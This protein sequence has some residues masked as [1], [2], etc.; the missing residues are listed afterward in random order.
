M[1]DGFDRV[2]HSRVYLLTFTT[3][4]TRLHGDNRGTVDRSHSR[5]GQPLAGRDPDR[6]MKE[7][8]L[9]RFAPMVL[10]AARRAIV[11]ATV[12]EV[13]RHR[14]WSLLALNVRT[15]HIHAVVAGLASPEKMMNDLK[16]YSTRRLVEAHECEPGHRVW[17][18]HGSLRQLSTPRAVEAACRY[19]CE[20]QGEDLAGGGAEGLAAAR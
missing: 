3:Y 8:L 18:R 2:V 16:A 20:G 15:N 17:T 5:P 19:V 1:N 6:A 13:C 11:T 10:D 12:R 7:F 9:M 4:G 14:D